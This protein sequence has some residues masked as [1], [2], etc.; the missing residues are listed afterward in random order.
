MP[1]I[2]RVCH[3]RSIPWHNVLG[4]VTVFSSQL[5]EDRDSVS[6]KSKTEALIVKSWTT[7]MNNLGIAWQITKD[8]IDAE[9]VDRQL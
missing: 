2:S 1:S 4:T 9:L 8:E 7:V 3:L 5:H 6:A